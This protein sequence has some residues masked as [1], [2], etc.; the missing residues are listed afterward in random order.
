MTDVIIIEKSGNILKKTTNN[1]DKLWT[2]CNYRNENN[3]IIIHTFYH[4]N[5][6]YEIYG[7]EKG[8]NGSE[9]I[10]QHNNTFKHKTYYGNFCCL[11]KIQDKIVNI[12]LE[13]F[14]KL[15]N[16]S[17]K[18]LVTEINEELEEEDYL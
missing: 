16:T 13:E 4:D 2:L 8:R 14:N 17:K 10:F 1:I 12:N 3:F 11:K 7:K 18:T 6:S 15:I 9:N 5:Y